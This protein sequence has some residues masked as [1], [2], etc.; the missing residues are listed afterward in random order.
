MDFYLTLPSN[1]SSGIF[2]D[3]T[4]GAY[5]VQLPKTVFLPDGDWEVALASISLPDMSPVSSSES[6]TIKGK[7]LSSQCMFFA[8]CLEDDGITLKPVIRLIDTGTVDSSEIDADGNPK[9]VFIWSKD[10]K[11]GDHLRYYWDQIVSRVNLDFGEKGIVFTGT[12]QSAYHVWSQMINMLTQKLHHEAKS[13][14]NWPYFQFVVQKDYVISKAGESPNTLRNHIKQW[15][16]DDGTSK[17]PVF[18]WKRVA[19][20]FE[21]TI[22]NRGVRYKDDYDYHYL[23]DDFVPKPAQLSH[24]L[25]AVK[26]WFYEE[27]FIT[28]ELEFAKKFH[29]VKEVDDPSTPSGKKIVLGDS[30]RIE[31]FRDD[32][33]GKWNNDELWKVGQT[34]AG[35][36]WVVFY[37][38]V[39]HLRSQQDLVRL[40]RF[41]QNT[42][43]G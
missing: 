6:Y 42:D 16:N 27:N 24:L 30:V 28:V 34:S 23:M 17:L 35:T 10:K 21:L 15:T 2:L 20:V 31:H 43:R 19:D 13:I 36:Y 3:N 38:Y 9:K 1:A 33:L 7:V 12:Q 41:G 22:N 8:Q 14:V 40:Q 37:S 25:K 39:N 11:A 18:E 5:K 29:M 4:P 32:N 26:R